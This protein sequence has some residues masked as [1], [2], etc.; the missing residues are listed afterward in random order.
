MATVAPAFSPSARVADERRF[1][2]ILACVMGAINVVAFSLQWLMGRSTF[3]APPLVHAHGLVFFGWVALF[4]AQSALAARGSVGLHRRLGWLAAGW[5]GAMVVLG[6]TITV[7][8]V[9]DGRTPFFFTPGYFLI[10]NPLGVMVFAGTVW[11]AIRM[12]RRNEWHRRLMIV[13]MAAIMGPSLGRVV[14][15]PLLIPYAGLA[16]FAG[17]LAF[18]IAGAIHDRRRCGAVHPAWWYG[19][20]L[21]CAMQ[22]SIELLGR[23]GVARAVH[24]AVTAGTPGGTADALAYPRPPWLT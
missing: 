6:I 10:M 22:L 20:A 15:L 5:A 11:W 21:L 17:M 23:S 8:T 7:V 9:R 14:P 1:F 18:P 4:V 16:V 3:G 24:A 19:I 13:G 12:R 2:F